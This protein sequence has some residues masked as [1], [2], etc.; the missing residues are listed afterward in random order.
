MTLGFASRDVLKGGNQGVALYGDN[1][2]N[3]VEETVTLFKEG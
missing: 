3:G 2:G 1:R